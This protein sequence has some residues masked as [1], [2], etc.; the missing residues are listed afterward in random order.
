MKW[1]DSRR[2]AVSL[3]VWCVGFLVFGLLVVNVAFGRGAFG[4]DEQLLVTLVLAGF[5]AVF[6]W[7]AVRRLRRNG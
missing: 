7:I 2:R 6:L 3:A 5:T 1:T 4:S